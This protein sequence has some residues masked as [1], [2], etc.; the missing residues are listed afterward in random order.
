MPRMLEY[1]FQQLQQQT[2]ADA[3]VAWLV[4]CSMLEIY[5]EEIQDLLVTGSGKLQLREDT[6]LGVHVAGLSERPVASGEPWCGSHQRTACCKPQSADGRGT[7]CS[8]AACSMRVPCLPV[9]AP[10]HTMMQPR[11]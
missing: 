10:P 2:A 7:T 5:C 9:V 8:Q 1:L 4:R 6:R 11:Q 3:G